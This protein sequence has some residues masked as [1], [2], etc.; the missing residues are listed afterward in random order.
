MI[1]ATYS[2]TP[3]NT[4]ALSYQ[5]IHY[6]DPYILGCPPNV[7]AIR[8]GVIATVSTV[9][10]RDSRSQPTYWRKYMDTID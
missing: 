6:T 2:N 3:I 8:T 1:I 4:E 10:E 9:I 7:V 5:P